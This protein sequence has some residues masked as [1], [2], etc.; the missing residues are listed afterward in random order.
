VEV[1]AMFCAQPLRTAIFF[2]FMIFRRSWSKS[3]VTGE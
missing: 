2:C 1:N 3:D